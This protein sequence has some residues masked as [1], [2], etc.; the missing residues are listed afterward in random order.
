MI[1]CFERSKKSRELRRI[2]TTSTCPAVYL[3]DNVNKYTWR[4]RGTKSCYREETIL[5]KDGSSAVFDIAL[6]K[7]GE[8]KEKKQIITTRGIVTLR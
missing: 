5:H 1:K 7:E 8:K 4:K 2:R 3:Y 6:E